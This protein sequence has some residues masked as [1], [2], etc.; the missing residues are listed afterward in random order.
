MGYVVL[1]SVDRDDLPDGG[2]DHFART[3]SG[4]KARKPSILVECL[5]PDFRWV[6]WLGRYGVGAAELGFWM[7]VTA[8]AAG[9]W[10]PGWPTGLAAAA[11]RPLPPLP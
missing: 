7:R 4:L 1:T 11:A 5:T 2:A 9:G 6:L 8:T 10:G 3:V